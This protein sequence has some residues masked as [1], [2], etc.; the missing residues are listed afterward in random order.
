VLCR[1]QGD[2]RSKVAF[3][4]R[5]IVVAAPTAAS[6]VKPGSASLVIYGSNG[7]EDRFKDRAGVAPRFSRS[8]PMLTGDTGVETSLDLNP[9][10]TASHSIDAQEDLQAEL[11]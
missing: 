1:P 3:N 10:R 2:C 4:A 11:A 9:V 8:V 7:P 6:G 5:L